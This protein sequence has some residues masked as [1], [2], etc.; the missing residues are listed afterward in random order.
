[1]EQAIVL[2]EADELPECGKLRRVLDFCGVRAS[3]LSVADFLAAADTN[4]GDQK[5]KLLCSAE[6][7]LRLISALESRAEGSAFW[8]TRVGSA[9]VYSGGDF[10]SLE[11]VAAIVGNSSSLARSDRAGKWAVTETLPEFCKSMSGICVPVITKDP[12]KGFR[13]DGK[14]ANAVGLI[15][16]GGQSA[17]VRFIHRGVPLFISA[18]VGVVDI[19]ETLSGRDFDIRQHFLSAAPLI[20]YIKWAFTSSS[21]QA[22]ETPACLV[23]DDPLLKPRY[24][25]LKFQRLTDLMRHHNFST[26]VAFIPWNWRRNNSRVVR[27]FKDNPE[28][29]SLSIHG[30]DHT[31]GEFGSRNIGR[32]AWKSREA[33]ARMRR[34]HSATGLPH[35]PVMVFPQGVFSALAM[36]VLKRSQFMGVVNSEVLSTDSEPPQIRIADYWNVAVLN[37]SEFPIFTRR[38]ASAG[39]ENFAFDI[40]LGKPCLVVAHHNDCHDDCRHIAEFMDRLNQLNVPLRWTNL[41]D[42]IRRSFRQREVSPGVMEIEMYGSQVR[43]ESPS[44]Q[45]TVFRF[46][47]RE[48][49]SEHVKSVQM[50]GQPVRWEAAEG[51]QNIAF[52]VTLKPGE[53][54]IVTVAFHEF[55]PTESFEGENL[56]Y[57][58]KTMV[59][60]YLSEVRDNYVT[61]KSFST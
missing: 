7:L 9:F 30:C 60:R 17:F 40:L 25:F 43:I 41:S 57:K 48:S 32:L 51:G 58:L 13:I 23:I 42:V 16:N 36:E 2:T 29:L 20:L 8:Q 37:Y 11:K 33:L 35:D 61:R 53:S 49:K 22:P 31:G 24:G 27:L 38:Y 26:S 52:E 19:Q 54:R 56:K 28:T 45:K 12:E 39:V 6:T 14:D 44:D 34:H 46:R 18:E 50:D 47:K 55:E 1:M 10:S 59:R 3:L 4:G 5:S 21:W 15:S